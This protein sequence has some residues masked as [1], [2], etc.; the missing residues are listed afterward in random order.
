MYGDLHLQISFGVFVFMLQALGFLRERVFYLFRL[1]HHLYINTST[2]TA[3]KLKWKHVT[4]QSRT[5]HNGAPTQT[6]RHG[7]LSGTTSSPT[8]SGCRACYLCVS[9]KVADAIC[10]VPAPLASSP[11]C[12]CTCISVVAVVAMCLLDSSTVVHVYLLW[13]PCADHSLRLTPPLRH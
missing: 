10:F 8:R 3:T 11:T 2:V 1:G 13:L 6:L 7:I 4:C 12:G 9:P 5:Q